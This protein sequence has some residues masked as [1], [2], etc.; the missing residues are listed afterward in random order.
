[1]ISVKEYGAKGNGINDETKA[2]REA[3]ESEEKAIN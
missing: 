1:M 2:F 3:F